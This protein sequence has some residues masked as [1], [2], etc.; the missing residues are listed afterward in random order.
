MTVKSTNTPLT[1]EDF[2]LIT[3]CNLNLVSR[4]T[5]KKE[6]RTSVLMKTVEEAKEVGCFNCDLNGDDIGNT[7]SLL[8]HAKDL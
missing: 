7:S 3:V 5:L 4:N 8:N 6:N 2:P 1:L